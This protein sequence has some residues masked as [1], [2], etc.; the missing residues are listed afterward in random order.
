MSMSTTSMPG[1]LPRRR[2]DPGWRFRS[3]PCG[4]GLY[5]LSDLHLD[6]A[7]DARLFRDDRQGAKLAGLCERLSR[8][9]GTEVVLLGDIFDFTAMNPPERGLPRFFRTLGV[10]EEPPPRRELPRL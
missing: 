9:P 8:E 5:V 4:V 10:P 2:T 7:G 1:L 3:L 6:E